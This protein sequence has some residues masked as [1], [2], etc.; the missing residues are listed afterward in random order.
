[1]GYRRKMCFTIITVIVNFLA[2]MKA[3]LKHLAVWRI[4]YRFQGNRS[5]EKSA[6]SVSVRKDLLI[7]F[8][9]LAWYILVKDIFKRAVQLGCSFW[10]ILFQNNQAN[11]R[12]WID[13]FFEFFLEKNLVFPLQSE[14]VRKFFIHLRRN[15]YISAEALA[16]AEA[17]MDAGC[18]EAAASLSLGVFWPREA[19]ERALYFTVTGFNLLYPL[20]WWWLWN[21]S[22]MRWI[23][24]NREPVLVS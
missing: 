17:R 11:I 21:C 19:S 23:L 3:H 13:G 7:Y 15:M 20:C 16:Y 12:K 2:T 24:T 6:F 9:K 10:D 8:S 18:K 4:F 1:M 14:E 22:T 5:W